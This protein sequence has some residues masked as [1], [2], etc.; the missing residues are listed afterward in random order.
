[1]RCVKPARAPS[2]LPCQRTLSP[3]DSSV[4]HENLPA[5]HLLRPYRDPSELTYR[6]VPEVAVTFAFA[7]AA[8]RVHVMG[9]SYFTVIAGDRK[10][11]ALLLWVPNS[12]ALT[13]MF[14]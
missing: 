7:I 4:D 3:L 9:A 1:M 10:F 12:A 8:S 5:S 2:R 6:P 14:L 11:V 13:H